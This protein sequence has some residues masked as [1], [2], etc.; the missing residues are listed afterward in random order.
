MNRKAYGLLLEQKPINN[1]SLAIRVPDKLL[2][3]DEI[4]AMKIIPTHVLLKQI[5]RKRVSSEMMP[6]LNMGELV[7]S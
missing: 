4:R 7:G 5:Y 2:S 1:D 6:H 3:C